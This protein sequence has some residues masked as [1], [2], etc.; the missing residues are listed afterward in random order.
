[1]RHALSYKKY[2]VKSGHEAQRGRGCL[3]SVDYEAFMSEL[4]SK[5]SRTR[6]KTMHEICESTRK[7]NQKFEEYANRAEAL[8]KSYHKLG[9]REAKERERERERETRYK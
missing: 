4:S 3:W 5:K 9:K 2:F 7:R 6:L 8:I 1:M